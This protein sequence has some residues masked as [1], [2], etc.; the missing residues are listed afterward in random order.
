MANVEEWVEK[1]SGSLRQWLNARVNSR[2]DVEDLM[3]EVFLACYRHQD[4]FDPSRCGEKAWVFIVAKNM[5][6]SYFRRSGRTESLDALLEEAGSA[7][8]PI[9]EA[10][11]QAAELTEQRML[12]ASL[13]EQ[14]DERSRTILILRFWGGLDH[15][16][17]ADRLGLSAGNVRVIQKR[18]LTKLQKIL[19]QSE[20]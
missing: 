14:L 2:E 17:I 5:L 1:Y 13:L 7:A 8:E 10:A 15:Q 12:A 20:K 3:Q 9:A 16:A 19:Q 18:A 11:S 6:Y 4:E